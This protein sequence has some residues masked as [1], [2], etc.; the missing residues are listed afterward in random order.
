MATAQ[1]DSIRAKTLISI[2]SVSA[3]WRAVLVRDDDKLTAE[4][5]ASTLF[6]F[7]RS[8]HVVDL[9]L[10]VTVTI[11]VF[12][13]HGLCV[14]G[15]AFVRPVF[16]ISS[17]LYDDGFK[18]G[19]THYGGIGPLL[20]HALK[21]L[22]GHGIRAVGTYFAP[23]FPIYGGILAWAYLGAAKR[24]GVVDLFACEI[25]TICRVG[26]IFGI[27][28]RYVEKFEK[29]KQQVE[30]AVTHHVEHMGEEH[31]LERRPHNSE[32][33]VSQEDYFP[34]FAGN[35]SDLQALE[36]LV[37]ANITEF[38]TYMKASRDLLRKLAETDSLEMPDAMANL[39][40]IMFLGYES[41]RKS[42]K[43]LIEFE[44]TRAEDSIVILLTELVCYKFLREYF[45]QR[46]ADVRNRRLALRENDYKNEIPRLC[47]KINSPHGGNK[48]FWEPAEETTD[49]LGKRY[50]ETFHETIDTA[51]AR[52]ELEE[53]R[54]RAARPRPLLPLFQSRS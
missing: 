24:L 2:S 25:S 33:F 8:K 53:R 44:P 14:L 3:L 12:V 7:F 50:S 1:G 10:I 11:W 45:A 16:H 36:A 23:A 35:S 47:R 31:A 18:G 32:T 37:V 39:I 6:R 21:V 9:R 42:I 49:E 51:I 17:I 27:A 52:I 41:G 54:E 29:A 15:F 20:R 22:V 46:P 38:Y 30:E 28:T 13:F 26:T 48:K 5:S 4:E 34:V 40:Y 19:M 43:Q